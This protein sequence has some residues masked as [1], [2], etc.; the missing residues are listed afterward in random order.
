[1]M[2]HYWPKRFSFDTIVNVGTSAHL[3]RSV[4]EWIERI[5]VKGI[6]FRFE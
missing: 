1:M 2:I 3:K 6:E 5:G 4:A